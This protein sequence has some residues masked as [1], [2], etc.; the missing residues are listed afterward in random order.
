MLQLKL[1]FF[2]FN[3]LTL[4]IISQDAATN[5]A[6]HGDVLLVAR[7]RKMSTATTIILFMAAVTV[8][9]MGIMG[10]VAIYR[11]CARAR[12]HRFHGF[13]GVPYDS[14]AVNNNAMLYMNSPF[15]DDSGEAA[16]M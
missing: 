1:K 16:V 3:Q 11:S 14:S 7:Q 12:L 6:E 10:G 15:R 4:V 5:D 8:L 13:C 2:L 9:F